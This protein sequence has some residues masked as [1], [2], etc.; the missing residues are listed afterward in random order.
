[1]DPF[2]SLLQQQPAAVLRNN[3]RG[4]P[5]E[6][7]WPYPSQQAPA[8]PPPLPRQGQCHRVWGCRPGWAP[9]VPALRHCWPDPSP[10]V[11]HGA[12]VCRSGQELNPFLNTFA[13]AAV[14]GRVPR[15]NP[16]LTGAWADSHPTLETEIDAQCEI[17][18]KKKKYPSL[19]PRSAPNAQPRCCLAELLKHCGLNE[20]LKSC[21]TPKGSRTGTQVL[22]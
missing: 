1:M 4:G 16:R 9:A 3:Q 14:V 7:T 15:V 5:H 17:K 6:A 19:S 11:R 18:L 12:G 21:R 10:W 13:A 22:P 2:A 8:V 20:A